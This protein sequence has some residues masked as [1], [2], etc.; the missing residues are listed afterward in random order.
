M[1]QT[2]GKPGV[3]QTVS[4]STKAKVAYTA[5]KLRV[6]FLQIPEVIQTWAPHK[7]KEVMEQKESQV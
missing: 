3:S 2:R 7:K 5:A 4:D 6:P 1:V